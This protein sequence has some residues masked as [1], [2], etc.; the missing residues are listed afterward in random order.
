MIEANKDVENEAQNQ[1]THS[2]QKHPMK[3]WLKAILTVLGV[4]VVLIVMGLV[5]LN[6]HTFS[7]QYQPKTI[8]QFWSENDLANKFIANG[9]QIEIQIPDEV[10]S[11]EVML[12]LKKRTLSSHFEVNS[13]FVDAK[14]QRL[15]MNTHFYGIKLPLSMSF[16]PLLEGDDMVIRFSDIVIGEGGFPLQASTSEKLMKLLFGNQL[17]IIL[18]SKSV[19]DVGI[20]KIKNVNLLED[21]YSFNIEIND[22]IIKDE[23]KLMSESANSELMAYFKD[24]AIES[25]KKAYYYLSNAD[26]LGNEDIE[27]LINDILSDCK[28]AESIFTLTDTQVSQEIFVRYEKYLKDIDSNLLIEK[29]KAHLTEILKP[30]CKEIMDILESV[31][32]AT[33]PLYINKGLPY[34]LATGESLSLSTVVMDQKVKV[35]AKMLNKMAFCYDKEND[36]LIISYEMSRGL[37]LLIYKEEAIMMTTE[38]YEK[39]FTPAGTGEAKWV[40]DVVTWDAISEQMK[41]YFQEENIYVRYMKADNQYAFVIASPKY[42][43]QNYWAFA[44]EMKDN[45]WSIIEENVASIE[46]LNKRHPDFNLKTVTNE[47]ETVQLHNLGDEMISVILD[48]MVNKEMIPTK[49]G[50]TIEYCS[51][52]NQYIDFLLTGG[53]EYVYLVYSMYLH[54][55][56]DKETAIKTWEDLP[57]LITLQDPPGIQ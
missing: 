2:L 43:Y 51:Y 16:L 21:H 24:S 57:D 11:T 20:V 5:Y 44:L 49:D 42:N 53:K 47:I 55:V 27:I 8:A 28:I 7:I 35:P 48:D 26:D 37:K 6:V 18:D 13:L 45:Q 10:L 1:E 33:D 52:G 50:I 12:I 30:V 22:A 17:P 40:Q 34:R 4:C 41:A 15:N 38:T 14:K 31:Y 39:T 3:R 36:R 32:F 9:N 19:L 56:Y 46:Y 23:L 54:T 25:E 29:K